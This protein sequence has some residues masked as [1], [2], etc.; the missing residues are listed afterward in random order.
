MI[1]RLLRLFTFVPPCLLCLAPLAPRRMRR[2]K[3]GHRNCVARSLAFAERAD[4]AA[5]RAHEHVLCRARRS[6]FLRGAFV[7]SGLSRT[8]QASA[9]TSRVGEVRRSTRIARCDSPHFARSTV[10]P[11]ASAWQVAGRRSQIANTNVFRSHRE[12]WLLGPFTPDKPTSPRWYRLCSG[13][14]PRRMFCRLKERSPCLG[15]SRWGSCFW[16]TGGR[17][18][19]KISAACT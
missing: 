16:D 5:T 1:D 10:R 12:C 6:V 19:D 9:A 2:R 13:G 8:R 14:Q 7:V 4:R 15:R 17:L 3:G 11:R 18:P